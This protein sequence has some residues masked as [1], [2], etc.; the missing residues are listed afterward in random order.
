MIPTI[1][2]EPATPLSPRHGAFAL[3]ISTDLS[4]NPLPALPDNPEETES[5]LTLTPP[6]P[7]GQRLAPS[8]LRLHTF[9]SRFLPHTE[10]PIRCVLPLLEDT[11]LLIGHDGGLS[12]LDTFPRVWTEDGDIESLGPEDAQARMMWEGEAC[13]RSHL[14]QIKS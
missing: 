4:S 2:N 11:L 12:V 5:T 7:L 8:R 9:G 10:H 3:R 13:V 14:S 6:A 1:F